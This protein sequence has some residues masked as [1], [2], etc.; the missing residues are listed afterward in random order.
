MAEALR[1]GLSRRGYDPT[2]VHDG[3]AA[4]EAAQHGGFDLILLDLMLPGLSGYRVI[5]Q[6]RATGNET[7]VLMLTAKDGEYDEADAFDLGVDDYVTKPF[8]TVVLL[9]RMKKLLRNRPLQDAA[10]T[11]GPVR[12]DPTSH[13]C[14]VSGEEVALTPREFALL[15]YLTERTDRV[16]SKTEL[17]DYV[18]DE[19]MLDPNVVEVCMAQLRRKIRVDLITTVRGVGYRV[20]APA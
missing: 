15:L 9:A 3:V 6:L 18:W 20:S 7:P 12:I 13:I 14:T 1:Q 5:E 16:V 11:C 8:S 17:L 19:P 2:V 10:I 4:L